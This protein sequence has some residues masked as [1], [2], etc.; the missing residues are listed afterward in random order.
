VESD[1]LDTVFDRGQEID[2]ATDLTN[3]VKIGGTLKVCLYEDAAKGPRVRP[4][5]A[6]DVSQTILTDFTGGFYDE[7]NDCWILR[8]DPDAASPLAAYTFTCTATKPK[9]SVWF[10]AGSLSTDGTQ[11]GAPAEVTINSGPKIWTIICTDNDGSTIYGSVRLPDSYDGGTLTF[12]HVYL[13][14]AANTGALNGDIAAQCRGNGEVPSSTW[15][16]EVAIDDAAVVGSNSNDMTTS[17]VVTAAGTCAAGDMLYW[18]YQ[19]DATGTTTTA[20]SLHHIGF[21]MEYSVSSLSD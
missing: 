20:A 18:R 21:N 6:S 2:S 13:Q 17:A 15:G 12:T 9:K 14:T 7:E 16:D 8:I 4:C 19:V 11:C 5:T 1:T 10:G 3:A